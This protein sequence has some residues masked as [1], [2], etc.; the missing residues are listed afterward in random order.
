MTPNDS[1]KFEPGFTQ[2]YG[3]LEKIIDVEKDIPFCAAT[4]KR[5][6]T[7]FK[8]FEK[9]L[10]ENKCDDVKDRFSI[11]YFDDSEGYGVKAKTRFQ[12]T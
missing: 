2:I 9:F 4:N 12:V 7:S 5:D 10:R 6:E 3:L 1:F 11:D 8:E